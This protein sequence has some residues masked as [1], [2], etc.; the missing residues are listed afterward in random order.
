M[1]KMEKFPTIR[2]KVEKGELILS[3]ERKKD[4]VPKLPKKKDYYE[5]IEGRNLLTYFYRDL[6]MTD[7]QVA[8]EI[9]ISSRTIRNW[10]NSSSIIDKAIEV[11]KAHTD[12]LVENSLL[13]QALK[14]NVNAAIYWLQ[15]RKPDKWRSQATIDR[16]MHKLELERKEL[17]N[18][19][20]RNLVSPEDN[21]QSTAQILAIADLINESVQDRAISDYFE[22]TSKGGNDNEQD[23]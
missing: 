19:K 1:E 10:R 3:N 21:E 8:N 7:E 16:E 20:L 13:Q 23:G 22:D 12:T 6:M 5:T 11:G 4:I 17:E 14:G 15:N 2:R 18:K 9:G